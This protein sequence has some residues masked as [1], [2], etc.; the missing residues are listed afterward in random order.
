MKTIA[1]TAI[2]KNEEVNIIKCLDTVKSLCDKFVILDTGSS[3]KTV[4]VLEKYFSDNN[5]SGKVISDPWVSFAT[6]RSNALDQARKLDCDYILM[7]DADETMHYKEGFELNH[8][9]S[10]LS[11]QVYDVETNLDIIYYRPLLLRSDLNCFYKSVVHEY[12][13]CPDDFESRSRAPNIYVTSSLD[14]CRSRESDNKFLKDVEVLKKELETEKDEFLISRYTF[15]LAESL[16]NSGNNLEAVKYYRKRTSQGFWSQEVF[17]SYYS[18]AKCFE[19]MGE[20]PEIIIAT[21]LQAF[22]FEPSRAESLHDLAFYCR[23]KEWFNLGYMYASRGLDI[24][25]PENGLFVKKSIYDYG[26]KDEAAVCAYWTGDYKTSYKLTKELLEENLFPEDQRLR[27]EE[28][29]KFAEEKLA[30]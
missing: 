16:K 18:M 8:F 22:E 5:L 25:Y 20:K 7:M 10:S 6:N 11:S 26:L 14:G 27:I 13:E 17:E 29:L 9:K 24:E 3:D 12:L 30:E 28:N 1:F 15:Y 19:N 4:Q 21:Y 23:S 2:V